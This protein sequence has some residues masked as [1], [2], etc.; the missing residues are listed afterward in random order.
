M[1]LDLQKWLILLE[2]CSVDIE[3]LIFMSLAGGSTS[4]G[5]AGRRRWDRD[6]TAVPPKKRGR[7][8]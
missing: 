3:L 6:D 5:R 1:A 4:P 8:K 7:K 2:Y